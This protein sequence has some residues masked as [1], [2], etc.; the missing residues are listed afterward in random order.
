VISQYLFYFYL[1]SFAALIVYWALRVQCG[2]VSSKFRYASGLSITLFVGLFIFSI[3]RRVEVDFLNPVT[4]IM[5]LLVL[6]G[7]VGVLASF[8]S[9]MGPLRLPNDYEWPVGYVR[10]VVT[11]PDGNHVVPHWPSGRVQIYDSQWRFLRGWNVDSWGGYFWVRCS[12]SGEIE[13]YPMRGNSR[14][15]FT[16]EGRLLA[17]ERVDGNW[18]RLPK[19]Q[20]VFV[21]T[22]FLLWIFSSPIISGLV[23]TVGIIGLQRLGRL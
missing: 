22:P 17:S 12:P 11:T 13:V 3:F 20:S 19:G 16:Q 18:P 14:Y 9:A 1:V 10:G 5:S 15:S 4:W 8:L 7:V 2:R 21:P 23:A 6:V